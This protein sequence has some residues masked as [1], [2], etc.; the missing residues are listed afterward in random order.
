[1]L[2]LQI[3]IIVNSAFCSCVPA[4]NCICFYCIHIVKIAGCNPDAIM[5]LALMY[6]S[7]TGGVNFNF[8]QCPAK[9]GIRDIVL[10]ND[11][12]NSLNG[13]NNIVK[14]IICRIGYQIHFPLRMLPVIYID[15]W[16]IPCMFVT[17]IFYYLDGYIT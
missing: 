3:R 2:P 17:A 8:Y 10:L 16:Y 14:Q 13:L 1:M 4:A 15:K 9:P 6:V 11:E 5:P 7:V 12:K